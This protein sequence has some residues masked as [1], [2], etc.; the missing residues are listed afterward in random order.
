VKPGDLVKHALDG[1]IG[2]IVEF[3]PQ[4]GPGPS[5]EIFP[6]DGIPDKY[7]Y[8]VMWTDYHTGDWF[9]GTYLEVISEK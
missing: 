9:T 4:R 1:S 6:V 2:L 8:R 5:G 3:D 7:P